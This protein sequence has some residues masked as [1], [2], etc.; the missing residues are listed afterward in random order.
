MPQAT[1]SFTITYDAGQLASL[2]EQYPNAEGTVPT[3]AQLLANVKAVLIKYFLQQ[4]RG[5]AHDK[6]TAA[7][8]IVEP[9]CE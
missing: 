5:K 4:Y 2:K 1:I 8:N 7:I 9:T 6:A 3:N